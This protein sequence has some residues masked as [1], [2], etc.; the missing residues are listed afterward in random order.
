LWTLII[1]VLP[2]LLAACAPV[3]QSPGSAAPAG[4]RDRVVFSAL[5]DPSSLGEH[6]WYQLIQE[7][8]TSQSDVQVDVIAG[9]GWDALGTMI[10]AGDAPDLMHVSMA[11]IFSAVP[12]M[13]YAVNV[14]PF[15]TEE[16]IADFGPLFD[17]LRHPTDPNHILGFPVELRPEPELCANIEV[18]EEAGVDWRKIRAEGWTWDEFIEAAQQITLDENGRRANEEGFDPTNVHRWA[19]VDVR[20]GLS[21]QIGIAMMNNGLPQFTGP[22]VASVGSVWELTG[23]RAAEAAQFIQDWLYTY[24]IA[25]PVTRAWG[26]PQ[27]MQS[28]QYLIDGRG[29]MNSFGGATCLGAVQMYNEAVESGE[30]AGEILEANVWPLPLPYNP[31]NME[32]E[33]YSVRPIY[34]QMMQ[35]DPFKGDEHTQNVADFAN[36]FI[37]A[38]T[39]IHLCTE[40]SRAPCPLPARQSVREVVITDPQRL[41]D[42][43][44]MIAR[45][46]AIP[47]LGHPANSLIS[48]QVWGPLVDRLLAN[49]I[50]GE[51][52]AEQLAVQAQPLLDDWVNNATAQD[53]VL[54]RIWCTIPNWYPGPHYSGYTPQVSD[55]CQAK[56]QE[57]GITIEQ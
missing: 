51:E 44:Y 9:L 7:Y 53:E 47:Q 31:E 15:L 16:D 37:S 52:F 8:N 57:L 13:P 18:F 20:D 1:T 32:S 14:A 43:E 29:A 33:V 26:D 12:Q 48:R 11:G 40:L 5:G 28:F 23:P 19:W 54:V 6:P 38:G 42:I 24:H 25:D 35:Q 3:A 56:M 45:G 34:L 46:K 27:F 2:A 36:W 21:W 17:N 41:S 10:L 4:S 50:N 39:Q 30:I 49:E 55:A 22:G